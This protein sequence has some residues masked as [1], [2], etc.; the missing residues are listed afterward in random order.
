MIG[1]I[2]GFSLIG[3]AVVSTI[4]IIRKLEKKHCAQRDAEIEAEEQEIRS[5]SSTK[6]NR[7]LTESAL[8]YQRSSRSRLTYHL[9]EKELISRDP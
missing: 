8:F 5:M 7:L 6:L 2:V 3:V 4:L 1:T 9:V